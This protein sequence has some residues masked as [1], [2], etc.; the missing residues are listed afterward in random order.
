[1]VVDLFLV[2]SILSKTRSTFLRRERLI[3][4]HEEQL[5]FCIAHQVSEMLGF[6]RL[7]FLT[8]FLLSQYLFLHVCGHEGTCSVA[9]SL[10][11]RTLLQ[12]CIALFNQPYTRRKLHSHCFVIQKFSRFHTLD[13]EMVKGRWERTRRNKI[14][15]GLWPGNHSESFNYS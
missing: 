12:A 4:P 15:Y 9:C 5:Y 3:K 8:V 13:K 14:F 7:Q 6:L 11:L 1:M 10:S 2:N